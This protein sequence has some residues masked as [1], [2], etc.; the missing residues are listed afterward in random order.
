MARTQRTQIQTVLDALREGP[1]TSRDLQAATGICR[2]AIGAYLHDLLDRG[3]IAKTG[4]F[5]KY[6]GSRRKFAVFVVASQGR[7][8]QLSIDAIIRMPLVPQP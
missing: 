7:V 3:L 8:Q 1:A 5:R 4:Y 2:N 6:G